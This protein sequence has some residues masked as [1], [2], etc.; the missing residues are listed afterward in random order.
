MKSHIKAMY[1]SCLKN[2]GHHSFLPAGDVSQA[3][4]IELVYGE[5]LGMVERISVLFEIVL[6]L[7]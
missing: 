7:R 6:L 5:G 2:S 4:Y 3:G 1:C